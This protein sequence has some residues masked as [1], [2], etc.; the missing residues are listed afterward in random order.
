MGILVPK[1]DTFLLG[2]WTLFLINWKKRLVGFCRI[3]P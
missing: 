1:W 2:Q 3:F